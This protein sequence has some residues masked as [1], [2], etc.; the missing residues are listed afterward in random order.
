MSYENIGDPNFI[1]G[2]HQVKIQGR[3][4]LDRWLTESFPE[5]SRAKWQKL[6][7]GGAVRV[8]GLAVSPKESLVSGRRVEIDENVFLPESTEVSIPQAENIPL[9]ILFEDEDILVIDKAAGM[10][11]H[12]GNGTCSGTVVNAALFHCGHLPILS[13]SDRPGVVHRLD[14][15]TSGVLLLAKSKQAGEGLFRQFKNRDLRKTYLALVQGLASVPEGTCRGN[16]GRHPVRRT[17]MS[18]IAEGRSAVSH[19]KVLGSSREENW[20][21]LEVRIE[22]GRTH[23]IRVHLSAEGMPLLGDGLYGFRKSRSGGLALTAERVLLHAHHL[24]FTHPASGVAM[25]IE[26]PIPEDMHPF[27]EQS[28]ADLS[29]RYR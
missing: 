14:K 16:I 27:F 28:G 9:S 20:S 21:A 12:P 26:A 25:E 19:W 8:D 1:V 2:V 17:R 3:G 5:I 7:R 24:C 4:R 13:D 11:V 23:Q 6:I 29:T 18:I 15:E 22:T 10:V